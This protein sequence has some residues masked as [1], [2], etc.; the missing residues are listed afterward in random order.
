MRHGLC[1]NV[2]CRRTHTGR[3]PAM[4]HYHGHTGSKLFEQSSRGSGESQLQGTHARTLSVERI[5]TDPGYLDPSEG[6]MPE[7]PQERHDVPFA[8]H[9]AAAQVYADLRTNLLWPRMKQ[10]FETHVSTCDLCPKNRG[11]SQHWIVLVQN[12]TPSRQRVFLKASLHR[13]VTSLI[14]SQISSRCWT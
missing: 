13:F 14:S 1:R 8:G 11:E 12:L 7:L 2:Y 6:L 3:Y 9:S 4:D 5:R 10:D